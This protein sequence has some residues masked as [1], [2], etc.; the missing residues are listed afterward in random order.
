MGLDSVPIFGGGW[1]VVDGA[2]SEVVSRADVKIHNVDEGVEPGDDQTAE[3]VESSRVAE[4]NQV[5][6]TT[7]PGSAGGGAVFMA[8]IADLLTD[9]VIL[10]GGEWAFADASGV[11]FANSKGVVDVTGADSGAETGSACG[12]VAA[13]DVGVG[14]VIEVEECSLGT[15]KEDAVA[16]PDSFLENGFGVR[17]VRFEPFG[18]FAIFV[19]EILEFDGFSTQEADESVFEFEDL[20]KAFAEDFGVDK[21]A[22]SDADPLNFVG[23]HG[24][25]SSRSGAD[26]VVTPGGFFELVYE[27]VVGED[28]VGGGGDFEGTEISLEFAGSVD[29]F[30]EGFGADCHSSGEDGEGV[31]VEYSGRE[32]VEFE[33]SSAGNDGV[34]GVV[35]SA[36]ADDIVG[37]IPKD[38]DDF[39]FGFIAPLRSD[40]YEG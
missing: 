38:V 28:D 35:S 8:L 11:S 22:H 6:P 2:S 32:E 25:D 12:G 31:G 9:F 4:S 30:E 19:V 37:L 18:V 10:F 23:V 34:S 7:A 14:S 17:Y 33:R 3:R 26:F 5:E 21:L 15:F 39:A 13:G 40:D 24:A 27:S 36:V 20:M 1:E 16:A 29:F